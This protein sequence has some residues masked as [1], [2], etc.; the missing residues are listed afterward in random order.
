MHQ[1]VES[2]HTHHRQ[3]QVKPLTLSIELGSGLKYICNHLLHESVHDAIC[4]P[5][6][7][8]YYYMHVLLCLSETMSLREFPATNTPLHYF[9]RLRLLR[10][11]DE[12][13][14]SS[15]S[16]LSFS[17]FAETPQII[18]SSFPISVCGCQLDHRCVVGFHCRDWKRSLG[19][20]N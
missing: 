4:Q 16:A 2:E 3:L 14:Y 12:T 11:W 13:D 10:W 1:N 17:P 6:A 18:G 20:V 19:Y 15:V 5:S 7:I 8:E 9:R